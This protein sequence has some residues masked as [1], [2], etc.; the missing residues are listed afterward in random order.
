M[1]TNLTRR[2]F[3]GTIGIATAGLALAG[4]GNSGSAGSG[5]SG[6][7]AKS[8]I[9]G[10]KGS[11]KVGSIGPLTGAAAIYGTAT[12]WGAQVAVNEINKAAGDVTFSYNCQDDTHV[13]ETSVNAY[14]NLKDW[15]LQ[16]LVGTTTTAPCVAVS[17]KTNKDNIFEL[18]PSASSVDVIGEGSSRK[19]NVFQMCFTDP[20]QGKISADMVAQK[21]LGTKIAI[22][23]DQGDTYSTGLHDGFVEEAKNKGLSIV[24]DESFDS[25]NNT[26][27][28]SQLGKFKDAG[29]DVVVMPFY[30]QQGGLVLQQAKDNGYEFTF[31]GMDGMDG[32]LQQDGFDASVAEGLYLITP[33]TADTEDE[34]TQKFVDAFS[35]LSDG[36]KPNQFAAD[37]YDCVFAI[38]Q[39]IETSGVTSD[40]SASD[41]CDKLVACFTAKDFKFS[42]LTGTDMTWSE[43]GT[44]SKIPQC[45][46]IKDGKYQ[47]VA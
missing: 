2:N 12:D 33:F 9:D 47:V 17:D 16:I 4:C 8:Q 34:N 11:F 6:E 43:D 37:A 21:K 23:H 10:P 20:N 39:A 19:S 22:L 45:Y 3:L 31:V 42:G 38:K 41:I 28:T 1:K 44:V 5:D 7:K 26:D 25:N 13:A 46:V 15:G 14:N 27:F 24:A 30:Y 40:M 32:I 18:T 35:K 36:V 29:A